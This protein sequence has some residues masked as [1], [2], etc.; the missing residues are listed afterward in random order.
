MAAPAWHRPVK[1]R[2]TRAW[3]DSATAQRDTA[4]S[5]PFLSQPRCVLPRGYAVDS[6]EPSSALLRKRSCGVHSASFPY[7]RYQRSVC[8]RGGRGIG[9]GDSAAG[10]GASTGGW[11][12]GVWLMLVVPTL[13]CLAC[14]RARPSLLSLSSARPGPRIRTDYST[15]WSAQ[16]ASRRALPGGAHVRA[17]L[18][19]EAQR[20]TAPGDRA[21]SSRAAISRRRLDHDEQ[22]L[23]EHDGRGLDQ[24]RR[25]STTTGGARRLTVTVSH[26]GR[27]V[28]VLVHFAP[29]AKGST[30]VSATS[31]GRRAPPHGGSR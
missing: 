30:R 17:P 24:R 15:F 6:P 14:A 27:R 10:F 2:D 9:L 16:R 25:G 11:G 31:P 29:G 1:L 26:R 23:D 4:M 3:A 12:A 5:A 20:S 19:A 28:T 13:A 18:Q 7:S 8:A 21:T 22:L